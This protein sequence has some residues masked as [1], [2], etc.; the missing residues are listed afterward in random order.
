MTKSNDGA[1]VRK[2]A[3]VQVLDEQV[4]DEKVWQAWIAK[5]ALREQRSADRRMIFVKCAGLAILAA[6]ALLWRSL[7]EYDFFIRLGV[8]LSG[9][10]IFFQALSL[11]RYAFVAVFVALIVAYN[12]LVTVFP[13]SGAEAFTFVVATTLPFAASLAWL[14]PAR[15]VDP[16]AAPSS[17]AGRVFFSSAKGPA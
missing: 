7:S 17:D 11:R 10:A 2:D 14:R 3:G 13:L 16:K 6:T 15:P 8:S 9:C 4:L 12:P 1:A 5:G